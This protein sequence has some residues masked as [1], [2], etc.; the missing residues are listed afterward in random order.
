MKHQKYTELAFLISLTILSFCILTSYMFL[1][2]YGSFPGYIQDNARYYLSISN[3]IE[4]QTL[5]NYPQ[6]GLFAFA[7]AF[8]AI[9]NVSAL[10]IMNRIFPL[11]V[12]LQIPF[13]YLV[14][15]NLT[16]N[17]FASIIAS[18]YIML[19]PAQ[20]HLTQLHYYKTFLGILLLIFL[21][22]LAL[23]LTESF[24]AR[25]I[26]LYATVFVMI[27]V[28]H[29]PEVMPA[30]I[31]SGFI[32]GYYFKNKRYNKLYFALAIIATIGAGILIPMLFIGYDNLPHLLKYVWEYG[33]DFFTINEYFFDPK[34][35]GFFAPIF[36]LITPLIIFKKKRNNSKMLLIQ[37]IYVPM[38]L[39]SLL[40]LFFYNRMIPVLDVFT[41]INVGIFLSLIFEFLD[42][43]FRKGYIKT[44]LS[45]FLLALIIAPISTVGISV[46]SNLNHEKEINYVQLGAYLYLKHNTQKNGTLFTE[47]NYSPW[48]HAISQKN[49]PTRAAIRDENAVRIYY[50]PELLNNANLSSYEYPLY[51]MDSGSFQN[52][53]LVKIFDNGN[54]IYV[55][56]NNTNKRS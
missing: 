43:H 9:T 17:S 29:L 46:M 30:S 56:M 28:T 15:K 25:Y 23:K 13:I 35:G 53:D 20:M 10:S 4:K 27:L 47:P 32:I 16:K 31:V 8:N 21:I 42:K 36:A 39:N 37:C 54:E 3:N 50:S 24:D 19:S 38:F 33:S 6:F 14:V 52:K 2:F 34:W 49:T 22:Y 41:A 40:G 1:Q 11:F 48:A 55:Y 18:I 26:I 45:I 44:I 5:I 7:S 12:S 51:F